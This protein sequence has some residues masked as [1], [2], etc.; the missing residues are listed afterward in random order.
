MGKKATKKPPKDEDEP[1]EKP[2][3]V[4][5]VMTG[6]F[7][8]AQ[9]DKKSFIIII[10]LSI[11]G[12]IIGLISPAI[13]QSIVDIVSSDRDA[14]LI[15]PLLAQLIIFAV[16]EYVISMVN[17]YSLQKLGINTIYS[18][19]KKMFHH[20]QKLS[21]G[22]YHL[23]KTGKIISY[24]TND[25]D[26]INT[27][28]STG[29]INLIVQSFQLVGA[30]V[31]MFV[32]S[33]HMSSIL[34]VM[35]PLN[36]F[37]MK[38]FSSKSRKYWD[39]IRKAVTKVTIQ[40]QENVSGF[41]T[42]KSFKTES[43]MKGK[44]D[45][46][47]RDEADKKQMA[48]KIWS[49][50]WATWNIVG[51]VVHIGGSM[52]LGG[53]LYL[54]GFPVTVGTISAFILYIMMF[55]NPLG[56]VA[57]FFNEI[58]NSAV[59]GSRILRLLNTMP[60]LEERDDPITLENPEGHLQFENMHFSYGEVEVIKDI[61]LE[62]LPKERLAIV[63]PTGAG[64]TTLISLIPRFYDVKKGNVKIDGIDVRDFTFN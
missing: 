20:L 52:L 44:F 25:V 3:G 23:N 41:R 8:H 4:L 53:I 16:C 51:F 19:R 60:D 33:I 42:I 21:F 58:Q 27:M 24:L 15:L 47:A 7:K 14:E 17:N 6:L 2:M 34:F 46:L 54:N 49:G 62:I 1:K 35:I 32:T 22:Y 61:N 12:S 55:S 18:I 5:K 57:T 64:K 31:M 50:T 63:G 43:M 29:L 36:L 37:L 38:F 59:G 11:A 26:T 9:L 28:I 56:T 45:E 13:I 40:A 48:A 10:V 39:Q 30:L